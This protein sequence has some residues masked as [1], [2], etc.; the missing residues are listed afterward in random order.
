LRRMSADSEG[1]AYSSGSSSHSCLPRTGDGD[2]CAC[3]DLVGG[4][5]EEFVR[6]SSAVSTP[7]GNLRSSGSG[8]GGACLRLSPPWGHCLGVDFA[9]GPVK[10]GFWPRFLVRDA[11]DSL[12]T[13]MLRVEFG[14]RLGLG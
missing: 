2:A 14:S 3:H 4:I 6:P 10:E 7:E 5:V 11:A 8:D 9:W 12:A 13:M 1:S